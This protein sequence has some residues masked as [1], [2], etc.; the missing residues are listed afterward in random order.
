MNSP[1]DNV[2]DCVLKKISP[3]SH[4]AESYCAG[5]EL[6]EWWCDGFAEN[7]IE[8]ISDYA[9]KADELTSFNHINPVLPP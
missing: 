5:F 2:P 8:W 6:N 3:Q 7:L 4:I 1:Y 9:L